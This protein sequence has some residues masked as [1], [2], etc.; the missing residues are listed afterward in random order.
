M[1][2]FALVPSPFLGPSCWASVASELTS[3]GNS[4]LIPTPVDAGVPPYWPQ[5]AAAAAIAVPRVENLVL[6]GHGGAGPLLPA[7]A[8]AANCDVGVY[9][10]VDA[11]LP[12]HG[13]TRM[14]LL[15][16]ADIQQG[17]QVDQRLRA[18]G[19][20]PDWT[21]AGLSEVVP[22]ARA[23]A[24]VLSE[25]KPRARDFFLEPMPVPAGWPDALC[26]Y[27]RLSEAYEGA[28]ARAEGLGWPVRRLQAG[29]FHT[30]VHPA[31]VADAIIELCG[32]G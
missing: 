7:I 9:L 11:D 21:D 29:H 20:H 19:H 14:E 8:D 23:R 28:A 13:V 26:A 32:L 31:E 16:T 3:R 27:L 22:G 1:A 10:F 18:G 25:F 2:C 30:V 24:E 4:V 17:A 5:H 15:R 12:L 6:A